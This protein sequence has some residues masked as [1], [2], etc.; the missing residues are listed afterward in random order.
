LKHYVFATASRALPGGQA[1]AGLPRRPDDGTIE[2]FI[3]EL[4]ASSLIRNV[5]A[6]H[7]SVAVTWNILCALQPARNLRAVEVPV[8]K[9]APTRVVWDQL[10]ASFREDADQY[11]GWCAMPDPLDEQARARALAPRTVHLR[12]DQ[13]HSAVTTACAA[14]IDLDR[15]TSL[16]M[17]VEPDV[18]RALLRQRWVA[19]GRAQRS[20]FKVATGTA[21]AF[22]NSDAIALRVPCPLGRPRPVIT[23]VQLL[24]LGQELM[25]ESLPTASTSFRMADAILYRDGL[26]IALLAFIPLRRKNLAAL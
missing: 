24:D 12:R 16:A 10:P 5:R 9:L 19:S 1:C 17:P 23:S 22:T 6:Q 21:G 8:N 11:L 3:A 4:E 26:M 25:D 18:F 15:L 13:I 2:C 7:R 14:G 20:C